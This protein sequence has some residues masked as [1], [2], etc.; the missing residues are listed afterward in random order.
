[1]KCVLQRVNNASVEVCGKVV[2][3]IGKGILVLVGFSKDFNND[4]MDFMVRK[5]KSFRLWASEEKGFDLDV[6]DINGEILVV[7]QFTLFGKCDKGTKPN[8][9]K[10]LG[11][12]EAEPLYEKFVSK[13]K[14]EGLK[15]STGRFGA[16]MKVNLENDGPVTIVL[17]K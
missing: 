11:A 13:L 12:A 8:F 7:S 6:C 17:E 4:K 10:S 15:V 3:K 1:M 2:G 9:V 14:E 5:I 16:Y